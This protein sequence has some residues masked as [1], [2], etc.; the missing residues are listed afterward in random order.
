VGELENDGE[1]QRLQPPLDLT[2]VGSIG[3]CLR[4]EFLLRK[5]LILAK[6]AD[7]VAK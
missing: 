7:L 1:G 2:H 3:L 4:A 6:V 5:A